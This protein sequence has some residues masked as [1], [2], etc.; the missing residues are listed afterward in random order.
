MFFLTLLRD[1]FID[2]KDL[3]SVFDK[4]LFFIMNFL[5]YGLEELT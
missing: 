2:N 5:Y 4:S 1:F 3:N